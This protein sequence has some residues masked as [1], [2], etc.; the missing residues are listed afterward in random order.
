MRKFNFISVLRIIAAVLLAPFVLA[1][2]GAAALVVK[3]F[4]GKGCTKCAD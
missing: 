4:H 2:L 1:I 3:I